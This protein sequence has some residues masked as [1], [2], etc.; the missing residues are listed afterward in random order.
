MNNR[1]Q[2]VSSDS[3]V[4]SKF[5]NRRSALRALMIPAGAAVL[6][7][8]ASATRLTQEQA[9]ALSDQEIGRM[10]R[11]AS[12]ERAFKN[13]ELYDQD[14]RKLYF[15]DD[16]I[17][18]QI[19]A[20]AFGYAKCTGI[21][22]SISNNLVG[23]SEMLGGLMGNPVRFYT[24]SLAQDSPADM[25]EAME[26]RGILG[27]PGWTYLTGSPEA[28][29]Y[30]RCSFGFFDVGEA[31]TLGVP[32]THTGM[33][34]FGHHPLDKWSSCPGLGTPSSI[35]SSVGWLFPPNLRPE[36][37]RMNRNAPTKARLIPGWTPPKPLVAR[38]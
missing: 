22:G 14:G 13:Y 23:A 32:E 37:A 21:C 19:F 24:F 4:L 28:I 16:L 27:K 17:R 5:L 1:N 3:S 34:R 12:G 29:R 35:A 25:R 6:G 8:C 31:D 15:H 11:D 18:G 10:R 38:A 7:G 9:P 20:A 36:F 30:I 2:S 26:T 33:I